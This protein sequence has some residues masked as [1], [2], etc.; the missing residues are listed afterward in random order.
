M[1]LK[2]NLYNN[3]AK[4]HWNSPE[5]LLQFFIYSQNK[6]TQDKIANSWLKTKIEIMYLT[7]FALMKTTIKDEIFFTYVL[8]LCWTKTWE[9]H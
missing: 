4:R 7:L 3:G 6:K 8:I 5:S 2:N 1:L 9:S